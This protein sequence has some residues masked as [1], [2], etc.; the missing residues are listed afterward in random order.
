MRRECRERFPRHRLQRKPLV[1]DP[2]MHHGTCVTHVPWCMAGSPNCGG[3]E[4]VPGI[5][6]ACGTRDFTYLSRGPCSPLNVHTVMLYWVRIMTWC[7]HQQPI[8]WTT[9]DP[10]LCYH[11]VS[12]IHTELNCLACVWLFW[13][14]N[15][16]YGTICLGFSL[17]WIDIDLNISLKI[18]YI[19]FLL[20]QLNIAYLQFP[21]MLLSIPPSQPKDHNN[22]F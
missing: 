15:H 22:V 4:N 2:G 12:P 1:S 21:W 14:W 16:T 6:G 17:Q 13:L 19:K 7:R 8:T 20:S 10:D 3:G 18:V 9:L 5:P 11:M